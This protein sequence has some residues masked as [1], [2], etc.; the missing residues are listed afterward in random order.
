MR[1]FVEQLEC[2]GYHGVFEEE[3]REGRKFR[4]DIEAWVDDESPTRSDD[5]DETL[6]Y[7]A[8]AGIA[9]DVIKGASRY[10]VE[11]LAGEI[12]ARTLEDHPGVREVTV[13]VRKHAPDVVGAPRWVGVELTK[14]RDEEG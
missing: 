11:S 1:I 14:R 13:R 10:L 6:D 8:L 5:I 2:T 12:A 3:R 4:V 9:D 7:R